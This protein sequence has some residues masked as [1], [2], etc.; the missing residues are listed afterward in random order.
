MV[1]AGSTLDWLR[2]NVEDN[3]FRGTHAAKLLWGNAEDMHAIAAAHGPFDLIVGSDLLYDRENYAPLLD[4]IAFFDAPALLGYPVRTDGEGG[5]VAAAEA[6]FTTTTSPLT[7]DSL[8][9]DGGQV[10][11]RALLEP[12]RVLA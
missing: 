4:T 8:A 2:D 12:R 3:G 10:A 7:G 5:F 1:A 6:R 9:L 11:R